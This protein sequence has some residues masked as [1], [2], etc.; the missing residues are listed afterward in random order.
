MKRLRRFIRVASQNIQLT[1]WVI[2]VN[3]HNPITDECTPDFSCCTS[4]RTP[5]LKRL[6][7]FRKHWLMINSH[8]Y[9]DN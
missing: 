5:F 4:I 9:V 6:K 2:G 8:K 7:S 3:I 1:L